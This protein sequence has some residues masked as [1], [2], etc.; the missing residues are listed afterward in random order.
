[1]NCPHCQ[2][3]LPENYSAGF[4]PH[5]GGAIQPESPGV[6]TLD[7]PPVKIRWP[8]FFGVL[9]APVLITALIAFLGKP[10]EQVSPITGFFGGAAAGIACGIMLALRI[11][12]TVGARI[13]HGIVLSVVFA[14]V[15]ITL[16]C[17]GCMVGGYNLR[18]D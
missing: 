10:N 18:L 14:V 15:C 2:K 5:C 9:L 17:F 13:V 6:D 4:C 8:I 1:M 7:L 11:G 12:K 16:S 3:P